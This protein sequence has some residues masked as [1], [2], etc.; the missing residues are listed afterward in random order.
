MDFVYIDILFLL[1][2]SEGGSQVV[3]EHGPIRVIWYPL[4]FAFLFAFGLRLL[5]R[6][7]P[8][9]LVEPNWAG[10]MELGRSRLSMRRFSGI[11]S[12]IL[13]MALS[14]MIGL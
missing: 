1:I 4:S 10:W 9:C 7:S 14:R 6:M 11:F 13:N 12:H 8:K 5:R 2:R 3:F